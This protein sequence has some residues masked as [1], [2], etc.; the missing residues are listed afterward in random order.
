MKLVINIWSTHD[1][2]SEKRQALQC[3]QQTPNIWQDASPL[4]TVFHVFGRCSI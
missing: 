3:V 4:Y 1:A 2:R